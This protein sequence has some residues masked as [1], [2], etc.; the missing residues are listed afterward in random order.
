M[1]HEV[2]EIEQKITA[3]CGTV[4]QS[5]VKP[6]RPDPDLNMNILS[7]EEIRAKLFELQADRDFLEKVLDEFEH[8]HREESQSEKL[9]EFEKMKV[10]NKRIKK[11]KD[12][13]AELMALEA[14][15]RDELLRREASDQRRARAQEAADQAIEKAKQTVYATASLSTD[16]VKMT[17]QPQPE[18]SPTGQSVE[19]KWQKLFKIMIFIKLSSLN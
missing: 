12:R 17:I 15:E 8:N 7:L 14:Q 13:E 6:G 16:D 3:D 5:P 10:L 1:S 18:Y 19:E 9:E 11:Y 2:E 4:D